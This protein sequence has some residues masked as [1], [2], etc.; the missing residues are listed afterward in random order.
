M[1]VLLDR[2]NE[3]RLSHCKGGLYHKLQVIFAYN[4]CRIEGSRLSEEQTRFI[5]ETNTVASGACESLRVD[6]N[7]RD[8][9]SFPCF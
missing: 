6:D 2:L 4:S 1:S 3:E 9:K 5:Y 7:C 8:D